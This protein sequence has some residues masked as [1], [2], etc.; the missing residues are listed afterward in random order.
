[1]D[2]SSANAR[3]AAS[4][5][6]RIATARTSPTHTEGTRRWVVAASVK[7]GLPSVGGGSREPAT[8]YTRCRERKSNLRQ[9]AGPDVSCA[10]S[11]PAA[12]PPLPGVVQRSENTIPRERSGRMP[13]RQEFLQTIE[14]EFAFLVEDG[15]AR[16]ITGDFNVD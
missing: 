16:E 2:S 9:D 7:G 14:S 10:V 5:T 15:Y 1:M 11:R 8:P 6:A 12:S 3:R 13:S 4:S